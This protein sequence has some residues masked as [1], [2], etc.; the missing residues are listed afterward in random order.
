MDGGGGG[1]HP[2]KIKSCRNILNILRIPGVNL[3]MK[4]FDKLSSDPVI[5]L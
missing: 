2:H 3:K 4:V 5:H 1:C